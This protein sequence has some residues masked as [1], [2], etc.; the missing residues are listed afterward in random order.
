M[1]NK[2]YTLK[3]DQK[4]FEEIKQA[5]QPYFV[6]NNGEYVDFAAKVD[7][8]V[9]IGYKS[10]KQTKKITF[11]GSSATEEVKKWDTSL[12]EETTINKKVVKEHWLDYQ[13]QIGSDEVGTGDLLLPVIVVASFVKHSDMDKL[14]ELGVHDS[15]KLTD[16]K[17]L[18]IGP[19]LINI[20]DY[21]KLTLP[22]EKYNN[23]ISSGENMNSIKAK[24]H[25]RA[26]LNL[27]KKYIDVIAIYVDQFTPGKTYYS[28][29]NDKN[30]EQ[31]K[32]ISFKTKGESYFPCVAASSVIARY[33]FLLEK[34]ELSKKYK[35]EFPCGAGSKVDDFA[36]KFI[37]KYGNDEFNKIAKLNFKNIKKINSKN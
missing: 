14:I 21:S 17:I 13:D 19:K 35:M 8:C 11:S 10:S 22:N 34:E 7:D 1:A 16:E 12:I 30:E 36:K 9:I 25:N 6:E 3:I 31:V 23:V 33:Y 27:H 26:L 37:K 20:V 2:I 29:L 32:G 4:T 5:Y 24:M 18:E 15:K 28:Y